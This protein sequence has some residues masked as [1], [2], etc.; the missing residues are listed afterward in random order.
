M[1]T[2]GFFS[3]ENFFFFTS[4]IT[5]TFIL[6]CI[7]SDTRS[8]RAG[9][10]I[11]NSPSTPGLFRSVVSFTL[12]CPLS[13][14]DPSGRA[15]ICTRCGASMR[16]SVYMREVSGCTDTAWLK[17]DCSCARVT[18]SIVVLLLMQNGR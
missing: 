4:S 10:V 13:G 3:R 11:A 9:S 7:S 12:K 6:F 17:E 8:V 2:S 18:T 5:I 1:C 14:S 16:G 15:K